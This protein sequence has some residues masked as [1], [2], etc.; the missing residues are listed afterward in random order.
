MLFKSV[1]TFLKIRGYIG[2]FWKIFPILQFY[3]NNKKGANAPFFIFPL[4]P[5]FF[6]RFLAF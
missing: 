4:I 6:L 3:E 5:E 1:L 2:D